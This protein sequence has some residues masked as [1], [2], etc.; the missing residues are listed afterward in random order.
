MCMGGDDGAAARA[1]AEEQRRQRLIQKGNARIDEAFSPFGDDYYQQAQEDYLDYY[2]PQVED[3]FRDYHRQT[4]LDLANKGLLASTAAGRTRSESQREYNETLDQIR[5]RAQ[6]Y[7]SG[8][9]GDVT[10][11]RSNLRTMVQSGASP[12]SVAS[13]AAERAKSLAAPPAFDPLGDLFGQI[14][15]QQANRNAAAG[16]GYGEKPRELIFQPGSNRSVRNIG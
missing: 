5:Q 13:I 14:A 2:L 16:A 1:R 3:Q 4:T 7:S 15:A 9:R 6:N 10:D 12:G 11:A 8:L